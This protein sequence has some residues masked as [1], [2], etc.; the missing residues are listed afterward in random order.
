MASRP[1]FHCDEGKNLHCLKIRERNPVPNGLREIIITWRFFY[2]FITWMMNF[3]SNG[4]AGSAC[5]VDQGHLVNDQCVIFKT[6][7]FYELLTYF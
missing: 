1:I 3:L 5:L 2:S 6:I 7:M 4:F